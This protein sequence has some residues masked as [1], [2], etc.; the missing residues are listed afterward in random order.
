[1]S[2]IVAEIKEEMEVIFHD[3]SAIEDVSVSTVEAR[4]SAAAAS[5]T[6]RLSEAVLSEAASSE[7]VSPVRVPCPSCEGD[8]HR[9]RCRART[10]TTVCGVVRVSRGS[11]QCQCGHI[12]VPWDSKQDFKGQYTEKVA[13]AMMRLA[14]QLNYRAAALELKHHGIH[15]S[16]TTLHQKVLAWSEGEDAT[17]YVDEEPLDTGSRWYISADGC[18]TNSPEG[19]KEVKVGSVSKDYPYTHA[20]SVMKVRP[21]SPRYV[22]SVNSAADFGKQLSALATQTGISQDEETI[23]TEEVVVIGD[24]AAWIWN[25]A[26]EHFPGATEIVDFMHAKTHLYDVAKHALGE[27]D[28]DAVETWVNATETLLYNGETSKVVARIRD[29]ETQNPTIADVLEREVGYFQKHSDRMQYQTFTEKGY[30]IGSGV[31]ESAC[32][33]VVAERCKQAGM[34][35]SKPGINAILFWRCLLKNNAWDTYWDTQEKQAA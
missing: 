4:V 22:A 33:H 5:W 10:F 29:L 31:I 28:R 34:R 15:V 26:D 6:Q 3:L 27:D 35:W 23:E 18:H 11:Y 8:S 32:K 2:D 17:T 12:H 14:A 9:Y 21:G 7:A 30:Q 1:M 25:L 13:A 19:W 24:G 20:T 16:H